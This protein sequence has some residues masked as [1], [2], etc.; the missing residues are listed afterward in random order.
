MAHG[1]ARDAEP[2]LAW[3]PPSQEREA[4]LG[5]P[6]V[7]LRRLNGASGSAPNAAMRLLTRAE[8][9]CGRRKLQSASGCAGDRP[10]RCLDAYPP[11]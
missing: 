6:E 9:I 10:Y 3:V 7:V 4:L 8:E 1:F 11:K 2:D 5:L